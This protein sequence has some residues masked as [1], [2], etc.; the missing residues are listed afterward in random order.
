MKKH[1]GVLGISNG[2]ANQTTN[3]ESSSELVERV[4]IKETPFTAVRADAKWFLTMGKYRLTEPLDTLEECEIAAFET[5]WSRIMQIM[6]IMIEE[7]KVNVELDKQVQLMKETN[8]QLKA[9]LNQ[10]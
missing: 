9:Q 8:E 4:E 2:N 1:D 6:A 5:S 3:S 7:Y 10:N